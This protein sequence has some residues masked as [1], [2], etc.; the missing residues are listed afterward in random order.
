MNYCHLATAALFPFI[1]LFSSQEF[2][3]AFLKFWNFQVLHINVGPQGEFPLV[4]GS[5]HEEC[6]VPQLLQHPDLLPALH[7]LLH[8]HRRRLPIPIKSDSAKVIW[9]VKKSRIDRVY[10]I[11]F[12][13]FWQF[14]KAQG[15]LI[16]IN[17]GVD[18]YR[19]SI[20]KNRRKVKIS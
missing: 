19:K 7:M 17:R 9:R 12:C 14:W 18:F 2:V 8:F 6:L 4:N 16:E 15:F 1:L 20:L 10:P 11:T 5:L 3:P 13:R